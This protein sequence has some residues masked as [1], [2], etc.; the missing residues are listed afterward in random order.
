MKDNFMKLKDSK[1]KNHEYRI[2]LDIE[3]T[4]SKVNYIIYTN[5]DKN[6]NGDL[7]CY[8]STYV[9]SAKGN[10]TK[11]KPVSTDE[12]FD[13]IGRILESLESE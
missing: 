3:D 2:I 1:G 12:E 11:L 10:I 8:A 7:I 6:K 4:S 5:E 9:L 13:F